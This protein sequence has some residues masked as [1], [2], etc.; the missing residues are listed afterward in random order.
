M[1][2]PETEALARAFLDRSLPK[3]EWTHAAHL[4]VALWHLRLYTPDQTLTRLRRAIC[5]YNEATGV[6]NGPDSGYHETITCFYVHAVARFVATSDPGRAID[7]Q[8]T[9]MVDALGARDLPLR[10]WTRERL[11]SA[12]ARRGWIE[13]DLAPLDQQDSR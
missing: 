1:S 7:E 12:E 9:E 10:H 4:Q 13:P 5:A 8:A 6:V 3:A 11:F 2:L